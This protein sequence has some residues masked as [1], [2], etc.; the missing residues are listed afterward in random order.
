M[1]ISFHAA[2]L[3]DIRDIQHLSKT[4]WN[5][6]YPG[7]ISREQIDH[8]LAQMYSTH[9]LNREMEQQGYRYVL[10]RMDGAD[11][12][13]L[14]FRLDDR[15]A[16]V[17][18][19]KIYL[20]PELHGKGLGRRMLQYVAGAARAAGARTVT[21]RVNRNNHAAI[22]AYERFGFTRTG[23]IVTDIGSG[24][25]MDDLTMTLRL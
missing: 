9:V 18:L 1:N 11:V 14:S 7:I 21:L 16:S 4:I 13:Y 15:E 10:V 23:T 24:F 25:V 5:A 19:S 2:A 8:M 6:H 17:L 20:L 3:A 12:G 22:R